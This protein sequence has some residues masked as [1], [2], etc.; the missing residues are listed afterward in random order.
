MLVNGRRSC[1]LWGT[2]LYEPREIE[3]PDWEEM[4]AHLITNPEGQLACKGARDKSW[5][6]CAVLAQIKQGF[7]YEPKHH[8][9]WWQGSRDGFKMVKP[10]SVDFP[11][12][13]QGVIGF[14]PAAESLSIARSV[15]FAYN[16]WHNVEWPLLSS[17]LADKL[18]DYND[19]LSVM[20]WEC[21]IRAIMFTL[22]YYHARILTDK[23]LEAIL[24][25]ITLRGTYTSNDHNNLRKYGIEIAALFNNLVPHLD[26]YFSC[27]GRYMV[28]IHITL[29]IS[30]ERMCA[31][32]P[33]R[34]NKSPIK[35]R[36]PLK[37]ASR[38]GETTI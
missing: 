14:L 6:R 2:G 21:K 32:K 28:E 18:E 3:W 20:A 22:H 30:Y 33:Y 23:D 10:F 26:P 16:K 11:E 19:H 9:E 15:D 25:E 24:P 29:L 37:S 5:Y 35:V 34:G 31:A 12:L 1:K 7:H 38:H 17:R 27:I 8:L 36:P 4:S 13:S